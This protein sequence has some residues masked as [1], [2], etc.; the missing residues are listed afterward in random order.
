MGA[1][2]DDDY[3]A[4]RA[5]M[6]Q[7]FQSLPPAGSADYWRRIEQAT[8]ENAL[9]LEVLARCV[10][11][12]A[13]ASQIGQAKRVCTVILGRIMRVVQQRAWSTVRAS[14]SRQKQE[15]QK[16]LE[17]EC[18]TQLW[19][20]LIDSEPT[21]F[22]EHFAHALKRLM[23]HA[24]H[25]VMEHEGL[26]KRPGVDVPNRVP[27]KSQKPLETTVSPEE[28][29]TLGES[30][31]D[32]MAEKAFERAELEADI[33]ELKAALKP[34]DYQLIHDLFWGQ[35]TQEEVAERLHITDKTVRNRLKRIVRQ[36]R[37][38]YLGGEEN[39]HGE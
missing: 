33:A 14:A 36:L 3:A 4:R 26:W 34:D 38:D 22:H 17:Q 10:R 8:A 20:E 37:T 2:R 16:E 24:E 32:P 35:L 21:W 18:Y 12:R 9:P 25:S 28:E 6:E 31:A 27:M 1:G 11:E 39:G 30:L 7:L 19:K 15:L 29:M 13:T 23:D 5:A